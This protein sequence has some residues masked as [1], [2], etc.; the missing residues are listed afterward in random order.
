MSNYNSFGVATSDVTDLYPNVNATDMG[1]TAVI[2][3]AIDRAVRKISSMLPTDVNEILN[4]RVTMEQLAGPAF[5]GEG[6]T[7]TLGLGPVATADATKLL[8]YRVWSDSGKPQCPGTANQT[9][10][11]GSTGNQTLTLT[12]DT[13]TLAENEYLFATYVI[14]PTD[15]TFSLESYGDYVVMA[16]GYELGSKLFD[17]ETDSWKLVDEYK[18]QAQ[19][20]LDSLQAG[21]FV[22]NQIRAMEFCEEVE[23]AGSTVTTVKRYRA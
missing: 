11:L 17:Q 15:A 12:G 8:L 16:A 9:G 7:F 5:G 14:D 4:N 22:D 13:T 23:P 6:P 1:G 2:Q 10:T 18:E 19:A 20:Y 3:A 21:G